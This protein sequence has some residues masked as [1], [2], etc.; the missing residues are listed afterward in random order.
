MFHQFLLYSKM[1]QLY[2]YTHSF[3]HKKPNKIA[4]SSTK[5]ERQ[6]DVETPGSAGVRLSPLHSGSWLW[7]FIPRQGSG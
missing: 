7:V 3:F 2:L 5:R 6:N 4:N 1:T